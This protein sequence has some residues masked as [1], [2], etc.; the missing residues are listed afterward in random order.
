[1][2]RT[3]MLPGGG[4]VEVR[5]E[6]HYQRSLNWICG[7][8][9]SGG[10]DHECE[11]MLVAEPDNPNDRNAVAVHI[12]HRQVGYLARDAAVTYRPV[13]DAL[14]G[15]GASCSAVIRGGWDRGPDDQGS[16]G[17][18]LDL[19][20]PDRCLTVI[21]PAAAS[22]PTATIPPPTAGSP[23]AAAL[24]TT[25]PSAVPETARAPRSARRRRPTTWPLT[26]AIV[27]VSIFVG[28]MAGLIIA[29]A[30]DD[31][32]EPTNPADTTDLP[33]CDQRFAVGRPVDEIVTEQA[34]DGLC[35]DGDRVTVVIT[36]SFE[37]SSRPG[38][39]HYNDYGWG[40]TGERWQPP[41]P[42][43]SPSIGIC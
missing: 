22:P 29:E 21:P 41:L 37:C 20:G 31:D 38:T 12:N 19:A 43:G 39:V 34:G 3:I 40:I 14:A 17:V 2:P 4:P 36:V 15:R 26:T 33:P 16:Y 25:T 18:T 23:T 28:L 32:G 24:L 8:R 30:G 9:T 35:V 13:M 7:G 42:D 1:M 10:H 6:S 11:A 5:G 27:A